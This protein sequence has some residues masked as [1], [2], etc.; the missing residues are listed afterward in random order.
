MGIAGCA[1]RSTSPPL[2]QTDSGA[3]AGKVLDSGVKAWL[4]IPFAR[5]PVQDLRWKEA[6]PTTWNGVY[7]ADRKMPA[8]IQVLRPHNINHY[9]GEEATGEDCLYLNIWAPPDATAGSR[10]PVIVFIYGGGGT[11]GSSG[12]A[13]Y[14]GEQVAKR[15]AIFVNFNYR[16]G[17]LGFMA[18]PELTQGAGRPFR[19][20]RLPRSERGVAVDSA[21][22]RRVRR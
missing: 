1:R 18:H 14:D 8:C 3:V 16:V 9:F 7:N 17:I 6:Q 12:M 13:N 20:L 15:G 21:Q 10:L 5:P 4:G 11:V 19:Q 22:H 2:V